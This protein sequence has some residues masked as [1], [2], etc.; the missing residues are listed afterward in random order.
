MNR[1]STALWYVRHYANKGNDNSTD[2]GYDVALQQKGELWEEYDITPEE[3]SNLQNELKAYSEHCQIDRKETLEADS[4]AWDHFYTNHTVNFFKD[5]H[6]LATAFPKEFGD[7]EEEGDNPCLVELG[8]GVGNTL[9]PLLENTDKKWDV[10]GIDLSQV[11]IGLLQQDHR[12]LE[13]SKQNRAFCAVADLCAGVPPDFVGRASVTSLFFCLSA[14]HPSHH[15]KAIAN[16][17]STLRSGGVLVLRDYGRLDQAQMK[18]G[19][20]RNK[21]ITD[22]FYRKHDGTKCYYFSLSDVEDLVVAAGL[23]VL[24]LDYIKRVYKNRAE[25]SKRR[26]VWVHGRFRKKG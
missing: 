6:Y 5:R 2:D 16:A 15:A 21:M 4:D 12:F 19:S 1:P 3:E 14:I 23:D 24:E 20:Q 17:A 25:Q 26:R 13:A 7:E 10:Y 9:L 18:L 22:N 11:A 8:C